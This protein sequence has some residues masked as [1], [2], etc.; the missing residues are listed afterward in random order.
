MTQHLVSKM[1]RFV[2][3]YLIDLNGTQSAIRAGYSPKTAMQQASRLLR[4]VKVQHALAA[5]QKQ[6]SDKRLWDAERLID[7]AEINL[8]GA[9]EDH[10]WAPA[11]RALE[12]IGRT[13]GLFTERPQ[14]QSIQITKV[15]VVLNHGKRDAEAR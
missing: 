3:E 9:R 7:E 4:N 6:L 13:A 5:R 11:N 12:L 10:A 14:D 1:T 15:T 2:D 8:S